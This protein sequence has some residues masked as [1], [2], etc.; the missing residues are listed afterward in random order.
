MFKRVVNMLMGRKESGS[1]SGV[2]TAAGSA[3]LHVPPE[4]ITDPGAAGCAWEDLLNRSMT[5]QEAESVLAGAWAGDLAQQAQLL[6]SMQDTWA[7][8]AT[9]DRTVGDAVT[10]AP[11]EVQPWTDG[12]ADATDSAMERRDLVEA[13]FCGM[14]GRAHV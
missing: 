12:E 10:G 4:A 11:F 6:N 5:P 1:A 13:A 3:P 14:I 2:K 9:C 8:L 7:M